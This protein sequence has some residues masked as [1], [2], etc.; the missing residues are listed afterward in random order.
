MEDNDFNEEETWEEWARPGFELNLNRAGTIYFTEVCLNWCNFLSRLFPYFHFEHHFC[1]LLT[2]QIIGSGNIR[3]VSPKSAKVFLTTSFQEV[4]SKG[5]SCSGTYDSFP[6]VF[7][8]RRRMNI[9][10]TSRCLSNCFPPPPPPTT[11]V[12]E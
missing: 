5:R 1:D 8:Y 11:Q 2:P 3:Y 6:D 12:D 4:T 10:L 9:R 7:S